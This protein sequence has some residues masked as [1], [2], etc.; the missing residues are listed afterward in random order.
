MECPNCGCQLDLLTETYNIPY[1]GMVLQSAFSCSC[2]YRFVDIYP[3]EEK[4]PSRYSVKVTGDELHSR[5][6]K[7]STCKILVPELGV[8][9]DPGPASEGIVTNVEGI[10]RRIE[11]AVKIGI[12]WGNTHQKKEG[13]K[14][15]KQM[16]RI[17]RGKEPVT[18][19]LEDPRGFSCIVSEKAQKTLLTGE[20]GGK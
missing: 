5:V 8:Q 11:Q 7:S 16:K 15:L 1:F 2:G 9:V 19:I 18:L 10:L 20:A 3:F 13:K 17:F 6:V 4:E 14:I 12:R